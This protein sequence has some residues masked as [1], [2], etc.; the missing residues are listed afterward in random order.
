MTLEGTADDDDAGT[1]SDSD[2]GNED[3]DDGSKDELPLPSRMSGAVTS[4]G[5]TSSCSITVAVTALAYR[6]LAGD[7]CACPSTSVPESEAFAVVA[8][9]KSSCHDGAVRAR[10]TP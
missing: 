9:A 2:G 6:T 1:D 5:Y 8:V 7:G 3:E 10:L 4:I